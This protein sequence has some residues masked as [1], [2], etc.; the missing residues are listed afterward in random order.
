MTARTGKGENE[1][2]PP[3]IVLE[4]DPDH[5]VETAARTEYD[6]IMRALLREGGDDEELGERLE[7]L[8]EFLVSADFAALRGLCE[9][10]FLRGERVRFFLRREGDGL[11]YGFLP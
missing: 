8:R 11:S 6:G 4:V 3:Q 9:E 5:C 7:L 2:P 1:A 10:R